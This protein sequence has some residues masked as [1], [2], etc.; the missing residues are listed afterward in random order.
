MQKGTPPRKPLTAFFMFK[1]KEKEKGV[2]MS[3]KEAGEK[4]KALSDSEKKPYLDAYKKAKEKYDKYMEE[5]EGIP[6][7]KSSSKKKEKPTSFK[8]SRIRAVCGKS[9]NVKGM[10]QNAYKGLGRV[11]VSLRFLDSPPR[12]RKAS[13]TIW[14]ELPLTRLRAKIR[15]P[16]LWNC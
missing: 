11:I 15:E 12:F 14:A 6:A 1:E 9:K 8:T 4:W 7:G 10:S 3:G 2:T 16:S 5:V 13:C